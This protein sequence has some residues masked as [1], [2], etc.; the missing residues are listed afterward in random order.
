MCYIRF[1]CFKCFYT[2]ESISDFVSIVVENQ[3]QTLFPSNQEFENVLYEGCTGANITFKRP[4]CL[5]LSDEIGITYKIKKYVGND[6][7]ALG[8]NFESDEDFYLN[9]PLENSKI[10]IPSDS[11][12]V[13]LNIST[14]NDFIP[15]ISD[16]LVFVINGIEYSDCFKTQDSLISF[17]IKDQPDFDLNITAD[18]Y[19]TNCPVMIIIE[20]F[21]VVELEPI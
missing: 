13:T 9:P 5:D 4:E 21:L 20:V 8:S 7:I 1:T 10:I 12:S 15:E 19:S 2:N 18:S 16:T 17:V 3:T 6:T 11:S 14:F